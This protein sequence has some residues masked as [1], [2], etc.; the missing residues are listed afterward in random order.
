M[1]H[2]YRKT[3][4]C[5]I[6]SKGKL[7]AFGGF[8]SL[9]SIGGKTPRINNTLPMST[10]SSDSKHS[11]SRRALT[12]GSSRERQLSGDYYTGSK[13]ITITRLKD[14]E[15]T[16]VYWWPSMHLSFLTTSIVTRVTHMYLL[17]V[18][19][20]MF[21]SCFIHRVIWILCFYITVDWLLIVFDMISHE[22]N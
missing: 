14:G 15:V 21:K 4:S 2:I 5:V 9:F 3:H 19:V 20:L 12:K 18:S 6:D 10:I 11:F 8:W 1:L 22:I 7:S 13:V 17:F 16:V